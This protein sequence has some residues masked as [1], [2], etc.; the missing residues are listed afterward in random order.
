MN[1]YTLFKLLCPKEHPVKWVVDS[2]YWCEHCMMDYD[3]GE[4]VKR[5]VDRTGFEPLDPPKVYGKPN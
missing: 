5:P 3:E 2:T 4:I 1:Q